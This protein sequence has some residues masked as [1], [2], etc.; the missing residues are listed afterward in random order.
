MT[1]DPDRIRDLFVAALRASDPSGWDAFLECECGGDRGLLREVR[2]LLEAHLEAG[3]LLEGPAPAVDDPAESRPPT[4]GTTQSDGAALPEGPRLVIGPYKLLQVIGEGGMGTVYLA[5][6]ARPVRRLVAL[7]V[8]KAGLDSRQVLARFEAERQTLALMDHPNIARVLDA[9]ATEQGR[10]YFVM[11]LV[12]GV[13]IAEFC[14][15]RRLT[16]RERLE[17]F[18]PVCQAVQHAHQKG[19]IHR[20]LKPSNVLVA[21]YDGRPVPRVIDFGV[22][23][24][25]GPKLTERTLFTE[26]GTVVGTP[27]YM[28]PEQAEL[29]QL[30]VD[31]R[32]DVY[33]LGVLLYELLTGTTPLERRRLKELS[34]LEALRLV[35]EEEPPRPSVRLSTTAEL[36]A[37]AD[38]RGVEPCRLRGLVRGELDWVVMKCLEKDRDR[39]YDSAGALAEDLRR[40]LDDE[41]VSACAPSAAYRFRKFARRNRVALTAASVTATALVLGAAISIGQA[42][43]ASRAERLAEARLRDEK[44]ARGQAEANFRMAR[45]AVDSMLTRVANERLPYMPGMEQVRRELLEEA[46]A[47]YQRFLEVNAGDRGLRLEAGLARSRLGNVYGFLG[48]PVEAERAYREAITDYQALAA[49]TPLGTV[50]RSSLIGFYQGRGSALIALRRRD[51][52]ELA[53]RQALAESERLAAESSDPLP[54]KLLAQCCLQFGQ[55]VNTDRPD[56]S[57]ALYRRALDLAGADSGSRDELAWACLSLGTHLVRLRRLPEAEDLLRRA[58]EIHSEG[59]PDRRDR[60]TF[61]AEALKS[62][63][64]LLVI[65]GRN[66]EAE[67]AFRGALEVYW[68]LAAEFPTVPLYQFDAAHAQRRLGEAL[69]A[70]GRPRDAEPVLRRAAEI[71]ERLVADFPT[72]PESASGRFPLGTGKVLSQ[73]G[74]GRA[75]RSGR[76]EGQPVA[77]EMV[78]PFSDRSRLEH[79]VES[80]E[81]N[82]SL[83]RLLERECR[84]DDAEAA[85]R[86]AL[87]ISERMESQFG[88]RPEFRSSLAFEQGMLS[89]AWSKAGRAAEAEAVT[90]LC[91]HH[92][93]RLAD[94]FPDR[95]YYREELGNAFRRLGRELAGAGRLDEAED[96]LRRAVEL[97]PP[98]YS[99][100]CHL[101]AVQLA[102][103]DVAGY[104]R[105]CAT[106]LGRFGRDDRPDSRNSVAWFCLLIPDAGVDPADL[107]RVAEKAVAQCDDRSPEKRRACLNTLGVAL[108][109]AGRYREAI[110]RLDESTKAHPRGGDPG[111]WL[112]LAMAHHRLGH[113]D[114]AR[115]WY[116]QATRWEAQNRDR[117]LKDRMTAEELRRFR[118]EAGALLEAN[119]L[120]RAETEQTSR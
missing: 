48:R 31:T 16:P 57:E 100:W 54:R 49:E 82:I 45:E 28:A 72:L 25:T 120:T 53:C 85:Y 70:L 73:A 92:Y 97:A 101:A 87:E 61:L 98:S 14:D 29:N 77:L 41:P 30:D 37:I 23:K 67:R 51:E 119:E 112:F 115:R 47:Y 3:S 24:A 60:D 65:Q 76:S 93:T 90:R 69:L 56:E 34:L 5:E 6:Q 108:Y 78:L 1:P 80:A 113:T 116:D 7:K 105:S 4:E 68:K 44:S 58:M 18:I 33:A 43:R 75:D 10:P 103:G 111:D 91:L 88:P 107:V 40:H 46:L 13:P 99:P 71:A 84:S 109:R 8:I 36:P 20:D 35:R 104:R 89:I 26:L 83:G 63:G 42:V 19:V 64:V 102:R 50:A 66:D 55:I 110:D 21:P 52:A 22:A 9:G 11:E 118:A 106:L 15:E 32:C 59:A 27:E 117:P 94:D 39:R 86:K 74:P 114:E 96:A 81:C 17:L 62:L 2:D 38:R 12:K 95:Q 79:W